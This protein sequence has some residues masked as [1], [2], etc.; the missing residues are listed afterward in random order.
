MN[1]NIETIS[2][3]IESEHEGIRIDKVLAMLN[4]DLSRSQIQQLIEQENVLVNDKTVKSS[5][6]V[7]Q[8]DEV[9]L[10]LEI[11]VDDDIEMENIPLDIVYE[12][13]D[14]IVVNK[15]SGMV[16][17]PA[18]GHKKHT[19]VNA[20]LYYT[21]EL[22]NFSSNERPGIVHRLDKETSGLLIV[23]KNNKAHEFLQSQLRDKTLH[24]EYIA[25]IKGVVP[26]NEWV[27]NAPIGR[28]PSRRKEMAVV[29]NGKPSVTHFEVIERFATHTLVKCLLETGRTH[30]IR[31]HLD[32][33]GFPVEGDPLYGSG[34]KTLYKEGQLLHARKLEFIH[35]TSKEKISVKT[36]MPEY[37]KDVLIRLREGNV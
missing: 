23:A 22:S 33:I 10:I 17:H 16:V 24:R 18:I 14:V 28:H 9:I 25:L 19:L 26:H 27:V 37:F 29:A 4:E 1:D 15:P 34:N 5:Y 11:E 8:G 7:K 30:Q 3:L 21:K 12:D 6:K 32:Y 13:D 35:P 36:D 20:L 31:V 2:Y